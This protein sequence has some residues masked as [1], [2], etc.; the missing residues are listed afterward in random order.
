[1]EPLLRWLHV[2][3]SG[4]K[5][6]CIP[7]QNVTQTHLANILSSAAFADDLL[8]P[9]STTRTSKC[10]PGNSLSTQTGLHS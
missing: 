2:G 7:G 6:G 3:E 10:K 5:H 1:M 4:Y 8:C 9:T